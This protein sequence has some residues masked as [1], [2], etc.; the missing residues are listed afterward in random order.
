M[1]ICLYIVRIYGPFFSFV[2]SSPSL[3]IVC[4]VGADPTGT[5]V[6][7]TARPELAGSR[8]RRRRPEQ[9]LRAKTKSR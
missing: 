4:V 2:R 1:F 7:C 8:A 9:I 6:A 3:V 5:L